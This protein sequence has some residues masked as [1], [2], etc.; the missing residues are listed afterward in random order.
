MAGELTDALEKVLD[1]TITITCAGRTDKGVHGW[2][3]VISFDAPSE[4]LGRTDLARAL[5]QL[6]GPA[7]S[8]RSLETAPP[9]FDARFDATA[10]VYRYR[11]LTAVVADPFRARTHWH[12]TVPLDLA[13]L[14]A[15]VPP[16]LGMHDFASFCR[17]NKAESD[18]P[19]RSLVRR[20]ISAGWRADGDAL[21]FEIEASSFCQQMVR[22]VVGTIVEVGS[23]RRRA[24]DMT[25]ILAARD[26][27]QAGPTAPAHGLMLWRV[28][29]PDDESVSSVAGG[30]Q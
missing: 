21:T 27:S 3:Q 26:R 4:R 10:R 17:S 25:G 13:A 22:A 6:C 2:G 15:A 29:Y 16:L 1:Q 23:G 30:D 9:G 7:I 5:N 28:R 19:P 18:R 12:V 14:R 11:I 24:G 8:V 20:V